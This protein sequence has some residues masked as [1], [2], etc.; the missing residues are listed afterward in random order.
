MSVCKQAFAV[1]AQSFDVVNGGSPS[2]AAHA[3]SGDGLGWTRTG[4]VPGQLGRRV[5]EGNG[6]AD[7]GRVRAGADERPCVVGIRWT[8]TVLGGRSDVHHG[9][10]VVTGPGWVHHHWVWVVLRERLLAAAQQ[11]QAWQTEAEESAFSWRYL[12]K[13]I[14]IHI[15]SFYYRNRNSHRKKFDLEFYFCIIY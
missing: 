2:P 9:H 8:R 14:I 7:R 1:G 11:S 5:V 4:P 12:Q 10:R 15:M 3:V 13:N 6:C